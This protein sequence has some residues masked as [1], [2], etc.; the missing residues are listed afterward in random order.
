MNLEAGSQG[1]ASVSQ[2]P[3]V[4]RL[5]VLTVNTHKGFTAFNRRFIL[6]ELREAVRSTQAD[7]VFLQEVLGS[8]DRHAAR[9]PGWPQTSQYEFLADSMWSDFAYGRNAVYPDGHH[10]NALLSKYPI[11]EHR[12]LDVSITGPERRGLLHCIL[13]VPGQRPVHAI[14]VHLSLQEAHRRKQMDML[15]EMVRTE[16]PED[17]PLVVAGDFNDWK[18][19]GNRTLGLARDLHEAFERH[20]GLLARTYPARLPL[21][22][23]DRIYL[24]N[25][26]SHAPQILGHKP[27]TH[28]SD[29]LPLAVEVRL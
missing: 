17:S 20:H 21:L 28:L 13:D 12:N 19:R 8:H 29:H 15:C 2:S 16:V 26:Q 3:A 6:P 18:L 7:I 4:D 10:G 5:R 11:L 9:Y 23:L 22:R 24:R 27:W 1:F 14:C 25:A